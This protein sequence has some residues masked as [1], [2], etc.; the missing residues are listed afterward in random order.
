MEWTLAGLFIF[1]AV[2]LIISISKSFRASKTEQNSIDLVHISVMKEIN[3]LKDSLR[4]LKL[5]MEVVT[6]EAGIQLSQ[7]EITFMREI[8]DLY[9]RN[10]SIESIA[11]EKQVPESEIRQLLAP[12]QTVRAERRKVAHEN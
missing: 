12:Y 11:K 10:Y 6:K 2:L 3:D 8:L 1:S 5:E 4:N 7:K 9:K